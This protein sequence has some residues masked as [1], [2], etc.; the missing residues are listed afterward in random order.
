M[1]GAQSLL[2]T[3]VN[4]GVETCFT[5]PGT[6]RDALRRGR[7]SRAR[8]AD[9][10]RPLE[11][12]CTGAADGYGRMAGKPA[13]TLLHLGPGLGNGFANLHNARRANTPLINLVGDHTTYHLQYDPPLTTDIESIMKGFSGRCFVH[14][15][16]P[17]LGGPDHSRH[18]G[19]V[20]WGTG[21]TRGRSA[22]PG[23]SSSNDY[24]TRS[25]RPWRRPREPRTSSLP[26]RRR[27]CRSPVGPESPTGIGTE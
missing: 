19:L 11:G 20:S 5:N 21:S 23:G 9:R 8:N 14:G 7:G 10:P 16:R 18:R 3:P 26:D 27:L 24:P 2:Q 6:S 13:P 22:A 17:P 1:T 15:G 4:G 12:V 25:S